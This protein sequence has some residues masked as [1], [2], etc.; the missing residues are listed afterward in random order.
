MNENHL[1]S[2][3][4][5]F[6]LL[7]PCFSMIS[8]FSCN[9]QLGK[10]F[11]QVYIPVGTVPPVCWVSVLWGGGGGEGGSAYFRQGVYTSGWCVSICFPDGCIPPGCNPD[12]C[13]SLDAPLDATPH[14]RCT[15]WIQPRWVHPLVDR[16]T[17]GCENITFHILRMH[18]VGFFLLNLILSDLCKN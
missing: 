7:A 8:L 1:G 14:S 5:L 18:S 12:R 17:D 10:Y 16:I 2:P 6:Y 11:K 3:K 9:G 13:I 15:S 4:S